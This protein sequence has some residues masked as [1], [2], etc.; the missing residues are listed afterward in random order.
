MSLEL[1]YS[2]TDWSISLSDHAAVITGFQMPNK[3]LT[4]YFNAPRVNP[5]LIQK[6]ETRDLFINHFTELYN[7]KSETWNAHLVL[8]YTKM[9]IRTAANEAMPVSN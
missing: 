5:E 6:Q 9:C 3:P 7:Q 2:K 4:R 8:E 1:K